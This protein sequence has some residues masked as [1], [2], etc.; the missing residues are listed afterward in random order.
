MPVLE[1]L[2]RTGRVDVLAV[3]FRDSPG[4]ARAFARR[5]GV[6]FPVLIDD[7]G[8][9]PVAQAYGVR[10]PP[11]TFFVDAE[12]RIAAPAVYGGAGPADLRPGLARIAPGLTPP[13]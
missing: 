5:L 7:D 2:A 13:S 3:S 12:G 1:R 8:T 6:K 4:D 9:S 11:M 10:S